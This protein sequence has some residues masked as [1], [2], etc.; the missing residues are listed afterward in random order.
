MSS[1]EV[2][3]ERQRAADVLEPRAATSLLEQPALTEALQPS[4][5]S[6]SGKV[7]TRSQAEKTHDSTPKKAKFNANAQ[8][9]EDKFASYIANPVGKH[10]RI[11][12]GNYY[13]SKLQLVSAGDTKFS[14]TVE[15]GQFVYSYEFGDN[16]LLVVGIFTNQKCKEMTTVPK[17]NHQRRTLLVRGC[18]E[19]ERSQVPERAQK[20]LNARPRIPST[21]GDT[22][23]KSSQLADIVPDIKLKGWNSEEFQAKSA[24]AVNARVG[25]EKAIPKVFVIL[26][27]TRIHF[28]QVELIQESQEEFERETIC[29][30]GDLQ[31]S[32]ASAVAVINPSHSQNA[33]QQNWRSEKSSHSDLVL[34]MIG[35]QSSKQWELLM[36]ETAARERL[37]VCQVERERHSEE[38]RIES[39]KQARTERLELE[40]RMRLAGLA[41]EERMAAER[42]KADIRH[43]QERKEL[44]EAQEASTRQLMEFVR[45]I[46]ESQNSDRD[47]RGFR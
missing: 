27:W 23:I 18:S 13:Y 47:R 21:R 4:I 26:G 35:E 42:D 33:H 32:A 34:S 5:P 14:T 7:R 31:P 28:L 11:V 29:E 16:P 15:P 17:G 43:A 37:E 12:R 44:R 38:L 41:A 8:K 36:Q 25:S 46:S 20:S 1:T 9:Q 2:E 19:I 10:L 39:E 6:F 30:L 45:T 24:E 40:A 22:L 3:E